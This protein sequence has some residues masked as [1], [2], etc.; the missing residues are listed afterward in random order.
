[1]SRRHKL[2]L[3]K[4]PKVPKEKKKGKQTTLVTSCDYCAGQLPCSRVRT[5]GSAVIAM[6][7]REQVILGKGKN[8]K[9]EFFC[10]L[11]CRKAAESRHGEGR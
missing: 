4:T 9:V 3:L 6:G 2:K 8:P 7:N 5:A 11:G 1:M 10:S